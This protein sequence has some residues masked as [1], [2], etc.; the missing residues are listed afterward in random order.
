MATRSGMAAL[1]MVSVLLL[2]PW[3]AD[4]GEEGDSWR[5][6]MEDRMRL[7]EDKLA[8]SE[9]TIESQRSQLLEQGTPDVA[10]GG[11]GVLSEFLNGLV[12]GGH[13]TASY[14]HNFNRP[15]IQAAAQPLCQF[16]CDHESFKL[17]AAKLEIGKEALEPGTAGFQL[18]LLWGENAG[19]LGGFTG[20]TGFASDN[21][22]H[23]Q[24]A[25]ASYNWNGTTLKFGKFETL[26]G[27]ELIDSPL[28]Y[29]ITHGILFTFAIPLVHTGVLASGSLTEEIGWALG[30]TNGF[31][32]VTDTNNNKGALA[33]L[34]FERGG[35][36]SSISAYYGADGNTGFSGSTSVPA[37]TTPPNNHD[38]SLIVDF[39][40]SF[41]PMEGTTL[42]LNAD[43][44]VQED[45][46]FAAAHGAGTRPSHDADWYGVALGVHRQLTETI[47]AA[48]RGEYFFDDDGYRLTFSPGDR[49]AKALSLTGTLGLQ[50]T[51]NLKTRA[52][53]RWDKL[54]SDQD[55]IGTNFTRIFPRGSSN[56]NSTRLDHDQLLAIWEVSY[57]FN[58]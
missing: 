18:D 30:L 21:F 42:W 7:L 47:D 41:E 14:A 22:S 19:I 51:D 9:A 53:L 2:A 43:Y 57:V 36:F 27:W 44:G 49:K 54:D 29:N 33:Q 15:D 32:N 37:S 25:Y 28:N 48:V 39:V 11:A 56:V 20:A 6:A 13:V 24:E 23:V 58:P 1:V 31:N 16:N 4:A 35:F 3:S 8:A 40:A 50:L 12:W 26:L 5:R 45:V 46:A 55:V 17:D 38:D 34:S 52:E 10:A